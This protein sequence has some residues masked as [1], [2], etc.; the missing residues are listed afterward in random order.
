MIVHRV[1]ALRTHIRILER[2]GVQGMSSDESDGEAPNEIQH[3]SEPTFEILRPK[4]RE[5]RLAGWL[6]CLDTLHMKSRRPDGKP[7]RGNH[8]HQRVE[9]DSVKYS[10]SKGFVSGLPIN[11]YEPR[12]LATRT[13]V[14]FDVYPDKETYDFSIQAGAF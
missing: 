10:K 13:D 5:P 8:P 6:R 4:W 14:D 11:A 12:W 9:G 7:A 2:L 3:V 1:S